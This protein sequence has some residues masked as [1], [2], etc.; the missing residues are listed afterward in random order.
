[1]IINKI[2]WYNKDENNKFLNK[3]RNLFKMEDVI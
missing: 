1:M 3:L 2:V